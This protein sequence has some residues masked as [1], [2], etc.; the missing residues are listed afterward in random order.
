MCR[1]KQNATI[2]IPRKR[3]RLFL[4]VL[5]EVPLA[6]RYTALYGQ[7]VTYLRMNIFYL[8]LAALTI[9]SEIFGISEDETPEFDHS[10]DSE[11]GTIDK[12]EIAVRFFIQLTFL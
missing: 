9:R 11:N 2:V 8:L 10:E 5:S 1:V 3:Q 6:N 7:K 12:P 4:F